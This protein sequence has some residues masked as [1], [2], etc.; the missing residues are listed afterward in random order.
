M[1]F[2]DLEYLSKQIKKAKLLEEKLSQDELNQADTVLEKIKTGDSKL[3]INL[4]EIDSLKKFYHI[5]LIKV[6]KSYMM[7]YDL[8]ADNKEGAEDCYLMGIKH[9][10]KACFIKNMLVNLG[11]YDF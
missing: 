3:S 1:V 2:D 5:E 6:I 8:K 7:A 10:G 9:L 11:L 4:S